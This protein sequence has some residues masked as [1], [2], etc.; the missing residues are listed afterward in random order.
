M[1]VEGE[2]KLHNMYC[3]MQFFLKQYPFPLFGCC[4]CSVWARK[5]ITCPK[6]EIL[7]R[8]FWGWKWRVS[9]GVCY[10]CRNLGSSVGGS[11]L[12]YLS[13]GVSPYNRGPRWFQCRLLVDW[14]CRG[15]IADY[16]A[17][18]IYMSVSFLDPDGSSICVPVKEPIYL[19]V[20][21]AFGVSF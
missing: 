13:P 15:E 21:C 1:C 17:G 9:W 12:M 4:C 16:L 14:C 20:V 3:M 8:A 10:W 19:K 5:S 18:L 7:V 11:D 2:S 6:L